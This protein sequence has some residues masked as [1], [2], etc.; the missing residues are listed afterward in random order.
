MRRQRT[1]YDRKHCAMRVGVSFRKRIY[2]PGQGSADV[3]LALLEIMTLSC[4]VG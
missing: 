2:V 3:N 4:T 1:A